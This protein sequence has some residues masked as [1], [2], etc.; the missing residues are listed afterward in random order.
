MYKIFINDKPFIISADYTLLNRYEDL[1]QVNEMKN[2]SLMDLVRK[3]EELNAKG[4]IIIV[5]DP[6]VLFH[7]F[8]T[9]FTC[10]D[11]GGGIVFNKKNEV[12]LIKRMGKWDIPKGKIDPGEKIEHGALREVEEECG[13]THLN[14]RCFLN[15]SYHSYKLQGHRFLKVTHWYLMDTDYTGKL[16]PQKEENITEAK[17][18]KWEDLNINSLDTYQS[19]KELLFEV[20]V[21]LK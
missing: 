5:E 18:F 15:K 17:W 3:T 16:V 11:A 13:I 6:V 4:C 7:E 19:I 12:L 14:I 21:Q 1:L 8:K 10:I 2:Q 20:K 9:H